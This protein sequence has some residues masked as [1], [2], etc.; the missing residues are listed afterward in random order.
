MYVLD[1][2]LEPV[3]VGVAGE[4]YIGGAGVAR[5]YLNRPGLTAE[6]FVPSPFAPGQR[7]YRTGDRARFLADGKLHFLGRLDQQ[8]KIRGFRIEPGEIEAALLRHAK[9]SHAVVL[10]REVE[11]DDTRLIAYVVAAEGALPSNEELRAHLK[12]SLPDYM[13]PAAF[14]E[15]TELPLTPNGKLDRNAL[16]SPKSQALLEGGYVAPRTPTEELLA[17]IWAEALKLDRVG[18]HDNFFE[19]GGHSLLTMRIVARI[20]ERT[21]VSLPVW[22]VFQS[23][24]IASLAERLEGNGD[25]GEYEG[26]AELELEGGFQDGVI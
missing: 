19:L 20:F 21:R 2:H 13:I 14:V 11:S 3:P 7:L 5:G 16:P 18:V 17:E 26:S 12:D 4:I 25:A 8:V 22:A 23:P 6:R 24:S 9:V 15:V 1:E 10:A